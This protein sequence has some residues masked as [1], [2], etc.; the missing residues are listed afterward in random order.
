VRHSGI[1]VGVLV[2]LGLGCA[3]ESASAA[4]ITVGATKDNTLFES[5]TGSISD[6][7]GP[8]M[9]IGR[10]GQPA[11]QSL[12]RGLIAFDLS[13]IPAGAT[14]TAVTLQMN[15]S[16]AISTS[17]PVELHRVT[18]NWGEGTSN[19]GSPGG[20]GAA[21]T[22]GDATWVHAVFNTSN[23]STA[24][25]DFVPTASATTT[26]T[27]VGA[28][29]WSGAGM[30]AD[31]QGWLTNP[32]TNFG[33]ELLGDEA[34]QSAHRF[35]TRDN[36]APGVQPALTVTYAVPEPGAMFLGVMALAP[37]AMRRRR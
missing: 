22:A 26:V 29:T 12:R 36:T 27:T 28:H 2:G 17:M 32:S 5:S 24:G 30:A 14:V 33:W 25:G 11:G 21:A 37:F 1:R 3:A 31:V 6:G 16:R 9:Y 13:S 18:R 10:T 35:D 20:A 34:G 4:V 15:L 23:W 8:H 19:S 7:L